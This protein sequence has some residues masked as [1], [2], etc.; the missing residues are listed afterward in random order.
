MDIINIGNILRFMSR[1]PVDVCNYSV[2]SRNTGITKYKVQEY[3]GL[4]EQT[5]LLKVMLPYGSNVT[6]EPKILYRL[7]FRSYF[8][9]GT[10][11]DKIIG[12]IR[13]EFFVHHLLNI[14]VEMNY[15]KSIRGEKLPDYVVFN[16][17]NK[18]IFEIGGERKTRKQL[19]GISGSRFVLLQ[20]GNLEKGIP[21]ILFG[22][23]F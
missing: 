14:D 2:I 11:D 4:L 3:I 6:R 13:E 17:N 18:I 9:E 8:S 16:K 22:F 21:L 1:S 5:F 20:P 19:K 12:A 7:P 23:L 10:E 15:L